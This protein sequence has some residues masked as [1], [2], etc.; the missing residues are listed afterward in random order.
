M[1]MT[2]V[3][4]G[5]VGGLLQHQPTHS[6]ID[7]TTGRLWHFAY[8]G[9]YGR[10]PWYSDDNGAT[11]TQSPSDLPSW[12]GGPDSATFIDND[13]CLHTIQEYHFQAN[14]YVAWY[15]LNGA[16]D[17]WLLVDKHTVSAW[18]NDA[19]NAWVTVAGYTKSDGSRRTFASTDLNDKEYFLRFDT[20]TAGLWS[21]TQF[22][23]PG[24]SSC[25]APSRVFFDALADGKTPA[26]DSAVGVGL[27][28]RSGA[29]VKI[30]VTGS[31]W[32]TTPATNSWDTTC[33]WGVGEAWFLVADGSTVGYA[34][35][36][37]DYSTMTT[38][39]VTTAASGTIPFYQYSNKACELPVSVGVHY[40]G[41]LYFF[42]YVDEAQPVWSGE[43]TVSGGTFSGWVEETDAAWEENSRFYGGLS[44]IGPA[45]GAV[46]LVQ[47]RHDTSAVAALYT[48]LNAPPSAPTWNTAAGAHEVTDTL[49][50]DWNFIDADPDD[51]QTEFKLRRVVDGG[52]SEWWNGTIWTTEQWVVS[53][54]TSVVY[55]AS[56]A[57][58]GESIYYY[59]NTKD[60]AGVEGT[61][62]A[63]LQITAATKANP[64]LTYPTGDPTINTGSITV[65]WTCTDQS[66]Y[67]LRLLSS[68][69]AAEL[70]DSGTVASAGARAKTIVYLL[71]DATDYTVELTTTSGTAL[72][73]DVQT[74]DFS[75][76]FIPP[77]V[78]TLVVTADDPEDGSITVTVSNNTGVTAFANNELFR[79]VAG[80]SES[81]RLADVLAEDVVYV[82]RTA[83]SD[84]DYEYQILTTGDN[85]STSL[86]AWT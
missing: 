15:E 50:V 28:L 36:H 17:E 22:F 66:A 63:G 9:N 23:G 42:V 64:V 57:T 12:T 68:P 45:G 46:V 52:P 34:V 40:N 70:W 25:L 21:A 75:T 53:T 26:S 69:G 19:S 5:N 43:Y 82:N 83:R 6:D 74:E 18:K 35:E 10:E 32:T 3:D 48:E 71:V 7:I 20:D 39:I 60:A 76:S 2:T 11:W 72:L 54:S 1:V 80:E 30:P 29:Y 8:I 86:S 62:S 55:P 47:A 81:I 44:V 79:R 61:E 67:R 65:E 14:T 59:V 77:A 85:L 84:V 58:L 16:G 38:S 4:I 33:V 78:A 56:W 73:S 41:V 37:L 31:T 51:S 49:T 13:G 24:T 27:S